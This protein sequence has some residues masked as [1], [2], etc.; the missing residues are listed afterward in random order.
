ML[1]WMQAGKPSYEMQFRFVQDQITIGRGAV[2]SRRRQDGSVST[3]INAVNLTANE[4]FA[5]LAQTNLS[6][7]NYTELR[8][9]DSFNLKSKIVS[10]SFVYGKFY[11][12]KSLSS[13]AF[14]EIIGKSILTLAYLYQNLPMAGRSSIVSFTKKMQVTFIPIQQQGSPGMLP[15]EARSGL[16][17]LVSQAYLMNS[18]EYCQVDII[19]NVAGQQFLIGHVM[20]EPVATSAESNGPTTTISA[21]SRETPQAFAVS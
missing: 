20:L 2:Q 17:H 12:T 6:S 3:D 1:E 18:Y 13:Y 5:E 11:L 4:S 10:L 9:T 14:M 8:P 16:Y 15:N 7:S 21:A 19:R